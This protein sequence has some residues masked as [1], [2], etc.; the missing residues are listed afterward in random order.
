MEGQ[1]GTMSKLHNA[2]TDSLREVR[3]AEVKARV[4]KHMVEL[5]NLRKQVGIISSPSNEL[6]EA[7]KKLAEVRYIVGQ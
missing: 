4:N 2:S 6:L 3:E 1:R 7:E 5:A